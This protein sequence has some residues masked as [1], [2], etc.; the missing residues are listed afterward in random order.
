[1]QRWRH[2]L[3]VTGQDRQ[4]LLASRAITRL[5]LKLYHRFLLL[6]TGYFPSPPPKR[7]ILHQLAT[8]ILFRHDEIRTAILVQQLIM[9]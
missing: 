7:R 1:M 8:A 5:F 3:L 9:D 4:Y 6:N 2:I